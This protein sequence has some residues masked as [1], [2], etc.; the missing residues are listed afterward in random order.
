MF[1]LV[2]VRAAG[3]AM[4]TV[5]LGS[6][7]AGPRPPGTGLLS[8]VRRGEESLPTPLQRSGR[9]SRN[10]EVSQSLLAQRAGELG[11]AWKHVRTRPAMMSL[12]TCC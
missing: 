8:R 9:E 11:R 2:L 6:G 7:G 4:N 12:L 3:L 5:Y 10:L 1:P